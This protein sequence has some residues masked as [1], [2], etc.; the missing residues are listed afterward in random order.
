MNY[1]D[2][3]GPSLLLRPGVA[4]GNIWAMSEK[5]KRS[6]T[7]FRPHFKTHQSHAVGRWFR[8]FGVKHITVSNLDMAE[9]FAEDGWDDITIAIP[10][11]VRQI[12]RLNALAQR[13]K[14]NL[15]V[16]HPNA[17]QHLGQKMTA[18]VQ[19]W[20]EVDTGDQR[21]G[22]SIDGVSLA[23]ATTK[24][25][26]EHEH[27][28]LVGLISHGGHSY[29]LVNSAS[30]AQKL[31]SETMETMSRMR[32]YLKGYGVEGELELSMGDTPIFSMLN[33]F[34]GLDEARPGNFVFFDQ[35]QL[36]KGI[37]TLQQVALAMAC[38]VISTSFDRGEVVVHGGAVHFSKDFLVH[39][40]R[41]SYN[42]GMAVLPTTHGWTPNE[43]H[44]LHQLSQEHGV[45]HLDSIEALIHIQHGDLMF[46]LPIHSCLTADCMGFYD[47]FEEGQ[48][49]ERIYT[50]KGNAQL[51]QQMKSHA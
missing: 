21:T 48:V 31:Y 12:P 36:E 25:I 34:P 38:P 46:F 41:K 11:N 22:L 49:T 13:V 4:R 30:T 39:P 14:L 29:E 9:Y 18:P 50:M 32:D 27:L 5:A 42:F 7:R 16:D 20:I 24:L 19:I 1:P 23:Y 40:V 44:F 17:V 51:G 26:N 6:G 28:T 37:C 33:E 15:V 8:D 47:L 10:V 3:E 43:N 35:M 45:V 2:I